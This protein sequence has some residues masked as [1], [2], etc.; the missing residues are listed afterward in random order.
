MSVELPLSQQTN[1]RRQPRAPSAA[2]SFRAAGAR[3][4]VAGR[5]GAGVG[6]HRLARPFQWPAG[7]AATAYSRRSS[8]S[9]AANCL[10]H[11]VATLTRVSVGFWLRRHRRHAAGRDLR[12]LGAGAAA[13]RPDRAGT[14]RD[15]LDRLGAA[16]HSLA[17]H[18]RSLEG[19]ADRGRRILSGLSGRDGRDPLGRSQDRRSRPHVPP[20]RSR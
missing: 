19:G 11:I 9:P 20:F 13:A 6:T 12:L 2:A 8:S 14:A 5:V 4:A 16:V 17:R 1:S 15:P 18:F 3:P 7:A 10:R